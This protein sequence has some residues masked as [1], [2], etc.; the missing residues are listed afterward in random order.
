MPIS[1]SYNKDLAILTLTINGEVTPELFGQTMNTILTS[2]E[3]PADSNALW[4]LRQMAFYNVDMGFQNKIIELRKAFTDRR[5]EARIALV[6]NY[7]LA[8]P[9]LKVFGILSE[10]NGL[11]Q[12]MQMFKTVEDAEKWLIS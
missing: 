10:S 4:D 8:E 3:Y 12:D 5:G 2:T 9:I 7:A 1:I 11:A 6:C